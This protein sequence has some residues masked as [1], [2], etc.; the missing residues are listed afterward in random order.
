M[1]R[2]AGNGRG[3]PRFGCG[4][5][6]PPRGPLGEEGNTSGGG[7]ARRDRGW[8]SQDTGQTGGGGGGVSEHWKRMGTGVFDP[9][10][11]LTLTRTEYWDKNDED[12]NI[13]HYKSYT[14]QTANCALCPCLG[15]HPCLCASLYPHVVTG[16]HCNVLARHVSVCSKPLV[17]HFDPNYLNKMLENGQFYNRNRVP[18]VKLDYF[19]CL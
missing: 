18:K 5:P 1:W 11:L 12:S 10:L 19:A 17:P 16:D 14:P 13:A 6:L 7:G 8:P 2:W 15:P 9:C 3:A 4:P